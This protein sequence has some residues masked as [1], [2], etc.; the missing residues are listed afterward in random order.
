MNYLSWTATRRRKNKN[1]KGFRIE[2]LAWLQYIDAETGKRKTL[3]RSAANAQEARRAL[4]KLEEQFEDGGA[5]SFE[6]SRM[7]FSDLVKHS[8]TNRYVDAVYDSHGQIVEGVRAKKTFWGHM[9]VLDEFFGRM[10]LREIDVASIRRYKI[11]R[12]ETYMEW[13][14]KRKCRLKGKL[15]LTTVNRELSTMRA[16]LNEAIANDFGGLKISPFQ[17]SKRGELINKADERKRETIISFEE[18]DQLLAECG[19]EYGEYRRHAKVL[20]IAA[21]ETGARRGELLGVRKSTDLH[22]GDR[23]FVVDRQPCKACREKI[24]DHIIVMSWKRKGMIKRAVPVT[25][26]LKDA[27][28]DLIANPAI[29]TFKTGRKSHKKPDKDLLFGVGTYQRVWEKIRAAVNLEYV[30]IHDLRHTAATRMKRG[31]PLDE[32]GQVLGHSD[33]RTTQ[34]YVNNAPDVVRE[35]GRVL[36]NLRVEYQEVVA[37]QESVPE[38]AEESGAVN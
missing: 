26:R 18:E 11:W 38:V 23:V 27:I 10:Q 37:N 2:H 5:K 22:F 25:P 24:G 8:K 32:V 34:R 20:L 13:R 6:H 16:M 1:G 7:T 9:D 12:M 28:L 4:T 3:C 17:R 19:G 30:R 31:L 35:A 36:H 15:S 33:P 14:A 21:L 29:A